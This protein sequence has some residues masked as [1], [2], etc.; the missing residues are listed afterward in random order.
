MLS[1]NSKPKPVR[2]R[3]GISISNIYLLRFKVAQGCREH[4]FSA[5]GHMTSSRLFETASH[6]TKQVCAPY[7]LAM[8]QQASSFLILW[9]HWSELHVSKRYQQLRNTLLFGVECMVCRDSLVDKI[10]RTTEIIR[11]QFLKTRQTWP[12]WL[13]L[14]ILGYSRIL[15][16]IPTNGYTHNYPC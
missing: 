1:R 11:Y 3:I 14:R 15:S 2:Y 7:H 4:H 5:V 9:F 13:S 8:W 16:R 12:F 10:N 6:T